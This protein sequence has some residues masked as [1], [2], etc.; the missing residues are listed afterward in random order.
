MVKK[1][2]MTFRLAEDKQMLQVQVYPVE[3]CPIQH[4]I[5]SKYSDKGELWKLGLFAFMSAVFT[6][7]NVTFAETK[8]ATQKMAEAWDKL[9]EVI[10][11]VC[12]PIFAG[13]YIY[14]FILYAMDS[15]ER[16]GLALLKQLTFAF[17]G[18][19]LLPQLFDLLRW[20]G[21]MLGSVISSM[22]V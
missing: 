19:T 9:Y 2:C 18:I 7:S 17:L 6:N 8:E 14:A 12:D 20:F 22:P 5:N 4:T 21:K 13:L 15:R 3:A 10:S 16:K 1:N 11:I